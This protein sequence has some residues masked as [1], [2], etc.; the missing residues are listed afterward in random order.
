MC[1][2][3]TLHCHLCFSIS[4]HYISTWIIFHLCL[5]FITLVTRE[6]VVSVKLLETFPANFFSPFHVFLYF[7]KYSKIIVSH[8]FLEGFCELENLKACRRD[9]NKWWNLCRSMYAAT[10]FFSALL[11]KPFSTMQSYGKFLF[12]CADMVNWNVLHL[13]EET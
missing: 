5:C 2:V 7:L 1:H 10:M 3:A 11:G 9:G 8:T 13:S 4:L 12:P 6:K